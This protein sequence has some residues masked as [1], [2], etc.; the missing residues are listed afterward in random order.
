[1]DRFN[2][3]D[4]LGRTLRPAGCFFAVLTQRVLTRTYFTSRPVTKK[5]RD[6]VYVS[7][8]GYELASSTD[9]PVINGGS[10]AAMDQIELKNFSR[11][12]CQCAW[13]FR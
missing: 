3:I 4:S 9:Q 7:S 13:V 11:H 8:H 6:I 2:R 10:V 5:L 1:M 12:L